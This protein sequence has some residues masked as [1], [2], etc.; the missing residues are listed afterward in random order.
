MRARDVNSWACEENKILSSACILNEDELISQL[1]LETRERQIRI[2][3]SLRWMQ[4]WP[5]SAW[6]KECD[7]FH[8]INFTRAYKPG[9]TKR[10][11]R[12]TRRTEISQVPIVS[13]ITVATFC[14]FDAPRLLLLRF[15]LF[16]FLICEKREYVGG[17]EDDENYV[18]TPGSSCQRSS[19]QRP[20]YIHTVAAG[21]FLCA[22][23]T[24]TLTKMGKGREYRRRAH[25]TKAL[26]TL[27]GKRTNYIYSVYI[28]CSRFS[29][30]CFIYEF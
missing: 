2:A 14:L 4:M 9:T 21:T 6:G 20:R 24:S 13:F 30:F 8:V 25:R 27:A 5:A 16:R 28:G 15:F 17:K 3:G 12:R 19:T 22:A 11:R 23:C 26:Q 10:G 18:V 1:S 7:E 29:V